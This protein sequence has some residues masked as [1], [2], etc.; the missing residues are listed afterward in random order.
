MVWCLILSWENKILFGRSKITNI[1]RNYFLSLLFRQTGFPLSKRSSLFASCDQT[2]IGS[3]A[4]SF[5]ENFERPR[6]NTTTT[7]TQKQSFSSSSSSYQ[8]QY[9]RQQQ[10]KQ[11]QQQVQQRHHISK[12]D[13]HPTIYT[14][15]PPLVVVIVVVVV[16]DFASSFRDIY[17]IDTYTL[18]LQLCMV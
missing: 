2:R 18:T 11:Q 8:Q 15:I 6:R 17:P 5:Q 14:C 13:F 9:Q 7:T 10:Q 16:V 4:R 12:L 1:F 3:A